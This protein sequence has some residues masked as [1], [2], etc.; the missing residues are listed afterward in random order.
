[1]RR[2]GFFIKEQVPR[3]VSMI[4]AKIK[5]PEGIKQAPIYLTSRPTAREYSTI[6]YKP[7]TFLGRRRFAG[8][9]N[10]GMRTIVTAA[11]EDDRVITRV[12]P[13]KP[14]A[15]AMVVHQAQLSEKALELNGF[16]VIP[17][18]EKPEVVSTT[19]PNL[20]KL[21]RES[22]K[23]TSAQK[24]SRE[25]VIAETDHIV[26]GITIDNFSPYFGGN[27]TNVL[28]SRTLE[29]AIHPD[30][31]KF[32]TTVEGYRGMREETEKHG[33]RVSA[34]KDLLLVVNA[35]GQY[36]TASLAS[37]AFVNSTVHRGMQKGPDGLYH[38]T[39]CYTPGSALLSHAKSSV[40]ERQDGSTLQTIS[41][42]TNASA[43]VLCHWMLRG[44]NH[45]FGMGGTETLSG[46]QRLYSEKGVIE[47][48]IVHQGLGQRLVHYG[49][50]ATGT[51]FD[52]TTMTIHRD[53]EGNPLHLMLHKRTKPWPANESLIE[54]TGPDGKRQCVIYDSLIPKVGFWR[55]LSVGKL[56]TPIMSESLI[57]GAIQEGHLGEITDLELLADMTAQNEKG[58]FKYAELAE[59]DVPISML[60]SAAGLNRTD[61]RPRVT[62]ISETGEFDN[63]KIIRQFID[64]DSHSLEYYFCG[65][66]ARVLAENLAAAFQDNYT[67]WEE[68]ASVRN[69]WS[70]VTSA[71]PTYENLKKYA[72]EYSTVIKEVMKDPAEVERMNECLKWAKEAHEATLGSSKKLAH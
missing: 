26:G 30:A 63:E 7:E 19:N 71:T 33:P 10:I 9:L 32:T 16:L 68:N 21:I 27:P 2:G 47:S 38:P 14:P 13:E 22:R 34:H 28:L 59:E 66:A 46:L 15:K 1:M 65:R 52:M 58:R 62:L 17:E 5:V 50:L 56:A 55:S 61:P 8:T 41:T 57:Q 31:T 54:I 37:R 69:L 36:R 25:E 18:Q 29:E 35:D 20:E 48:L 64:Q 45:L 51:P 12:K 60:M 6:G 42:A 24:S 44:V 39:T 43:D 72:E 70:I 3:V 4:M 11:H 49:L 23:L 40:A 53:K 67:I